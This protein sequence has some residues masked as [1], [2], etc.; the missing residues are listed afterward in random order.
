MP[1]T[2]LLGLNELFQEPLSRVRAVHPGRVAL[3]LT[4]PSSCKNKPVLATGRGEQ[5]EVM[6]PFVALRGSAFLL[7]HPGFGVP[8]AWAYAQLRHYPSAL[9]G[10]PG[11]AREVVSLLQSG[12]LAP[13]GAALYNA[14]EAPVLDKYPYLALLKEFL[15]KNYKNKKN[16]NK[17]TKAKKKKNKKDKPPPL[18]Q[19]PIQGILK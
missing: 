12:D 3:A 15:Q 13:A 16:K 11:R 5:L 9:N 14:L 17:K 10:Q 4:F 2:A 6:E 8:T 18:N 7:I 1:A 19:P